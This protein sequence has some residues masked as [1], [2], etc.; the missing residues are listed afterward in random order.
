M[1]QVENDKVKLERVGC[2]YTY[3]SNE[4]YE[5]V[6]FIARQ[7]LKGADMS[8]VASNEFRERFA[9]SIAEL[10]VSDWERLVFDERCDPN[11][12]GDYT[13]S[14]YMYIVRKK[15]KKTE[16]YDNTTSY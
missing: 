1:I 7:S 5:R 11:E 15:D 12:S 6:R 4:M 16:S 13:C 14:A 2:S 9:K 10:I 8:R 3:S